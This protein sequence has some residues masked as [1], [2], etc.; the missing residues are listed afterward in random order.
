MVCSTCEDY[1]FKE[2]NLK[3]TYV[4][5][6]VPNIGSWKVVEKLGFT[7]ESTSKH[8]FYVK[9]KYLDVKKYYLLKED[10]IKM[11]LLRWI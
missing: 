4:N 10:W 7:F 11:N 3:K 5:I 2:L 1:S 6:A 8:E 9:G